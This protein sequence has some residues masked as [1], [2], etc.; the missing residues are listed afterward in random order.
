MCEFIR[1]GIFE[2]SSIKEFEELYR[3]ESWQD[4]LFQPK[5]N[6]RISN[7]QHPFSH[8]I[9]SQLSMVFQVILH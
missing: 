7:M 3:Y 9:A 4:C 2:V 1:P 6:S 5:K 8:F